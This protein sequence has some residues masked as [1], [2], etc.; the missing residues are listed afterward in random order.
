M[1]IDLNIDR[2]VATISSKDNVMVP[3]WRLTLFF[4]SLL[5]I[6]VAMINAIGEPSL[7][8]NW[9]LYVTVCFTFWFSLY[10]LT[11]YKYF[12]SVYLFTTAYI[13]CLFVFHLGHSF[14]H[15]LGW[16]E[17]KNLVTGNMAAFF[18]RA[19]WY[20]LIALGAMGIGLSLSLKGGKTNIKNYDDIKNIW[21]KTQQNAFSIGIALFIAS[22]LSLI[23]LAYS[24]GNILAFS[25]VEIFRGLGD[26][27]G[28]GFFLNV[29]PSSAIL[30]IIGANTYKKK[31]FA[32]INAIVVLLTLLFLGYRSSALFAAMAGAVVWVPVG[33]R[34]PIFILGCAIIFVF[35]AIPTVRYLRASGP[36]KDISATKVIEAFRQSKVEDSIN[37]IGGTSSIVAYVLKWVP[38][39]D[40]YRY[41][42]SYLLAFIDS[43]PNL[44]LSPE[45]SSRPEV[46]RQG[47][48]D[49]V[50]LRKL[51][52]AEWYTFKT[53]KRM[54]E[55]GG[56]TGFSTIAEPYLN[57]GFPG[58]V[59]YFFALGL[60]FRT[61]TGRTEE[62]SQNSHFCSCH[63][64]ASSENRA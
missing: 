55:T 33:R 14:A 11:T 1:K 8:K 2:N 24:V 38:N 9:P 16:F 12:N 36:Y 50:A 56:G 7:N 18:E 15:G 59:L 3:I 43:I 53:N 46:R 34:I 35:I 13:I 52:P 48:I 61:R 63:V 60:L 4:V 6:A 58:L 27:R 30:L 49:I 28:F 54:F 44:G 22:I 57:F 5:L 51:R 21:E 42:Q 37:E 20:C 19:G 29:I 45:A 26:T 39:D 64:L 40:P 10:L 32:Y 41:G 62:S 47:F 17:V 31:T 23:I 25:R